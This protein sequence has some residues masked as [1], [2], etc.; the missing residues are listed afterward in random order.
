VRRAVRQ[1][2]RIYQDQALRDQIQLRGHV[3]TGPGNSEVAIARLMAA[4]SSVVAVP[5]PKEPP[6]P[7]V[8]YPRRTQPR[9]L[10]RWHSS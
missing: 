6:P 1:V 10:R 8:P 4:L 7:P 3:N 5:L 2:Q 9:P